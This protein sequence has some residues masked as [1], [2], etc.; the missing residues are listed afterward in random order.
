MKNLFKKGEFIIFLFSA[1]W[2]FAGIILIV[3]QKAEIHLFLNAYHT[4]FSDT[5]FKYITNLGDGLMPLILFVIFLFFSF[6][7]AFIIGLSGAATGLLA[8]FFKRVIFK[9][10]AR[11]SAFFKD[12]ADLYLV[13]GVEVHQS[14]SF[15]SGHSATVFGLFIVLALFS[16][17]K[18]TQ[19]VL[20]IVA[21]LT[22]YSRIYL[23]QHFLVDVYFGA[24]LGV[25]TSFFTMVL[26][27]KI[28]RPWIDNSIIKLLNN[29]NE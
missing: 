8:Q 14:F 12:I 29:K 6:R 22:G 9:D 25:T 11:P 21:I 24:I 20:L 19:L 7:K 17:S 23:S 27:E 5:F 3:W 4:G 18:T 26:M 16:K 15:P 2:I 1:I 28:K 13:P 10:I